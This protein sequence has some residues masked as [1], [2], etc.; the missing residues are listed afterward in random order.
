MCFHG[1]RAPRASWWRSRAAGGRNA[2]NLRG[3]GQRCSRPTPRHHPGLP[4][5]A[6][7]VAGG[8]RGAASARYSPQAP[9]GHRAGAREQLQHLSMGE[10][11]GAPRLVLGLLGELSHIHERGLAARSSRWISDGA[12]GGQMRCAG[13]R[14]GRSRRC[15]YKLPEV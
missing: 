10:P 6:E 5:A 15:E 9:A 1:C 14:R 8:R 3:I 4:G 2:A 12:G 7:A 13:A 11:A